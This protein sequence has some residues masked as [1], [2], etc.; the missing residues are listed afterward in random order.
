IQLDQ[1]I[2]AA[3]TAMVKAQQDADSQLAILAINEEGR[4]TK[5][6]HAIQTYVD[7]L[8]Q[9]AAA[10]QRQGER[11][12]AGVGMG[13]RQASLSGALNSIEDHANQLR[14]DLAR[15]KADKARNMS[16]EEY[17]QKLDAINRSEKE[18]AE[19]TIDNYE[20]MT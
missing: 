15:D 19:A 17:Q 10:L 2:G 7:A 14:L 12:A 18:L 13:D 5:Q 16:A 1:R 11:A 3:R 20:L 4:L 8:D 6:A 9:Q